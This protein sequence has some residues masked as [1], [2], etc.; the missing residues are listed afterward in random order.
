MPPRVPSSEKYVWT[1][2]AEPPA[3]G[4][5][6]P[7]IRVLQTCP[8]LRKDQHCYC[9]FDT[10]AIAA[11]LE[12]AGAAAVAEWFLT[13]LEA[14][15]IPDLIT[16]FERAVNRTSADEEAAGRLRLVLADLKRLEE[17]GSG[18]TDEYSD[19]LD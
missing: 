9:R 18:L 13:P 5:S 16:D 11:D 15:D 4:R 19:D 10:G 2:T 6:G 17:A 7:S 3:C 12:E 8:R 1:M 14:D